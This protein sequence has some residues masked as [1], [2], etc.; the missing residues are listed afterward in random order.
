MRYVLVEVSR[1]EPFPGCGSTFYERARRENAS[2][3][4]FV[5]E[6]GVMFHMLQPGE[7]WEHVA[8]RFGYTASDA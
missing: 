3:A 7:T 8:R 2:I 4:R 1:S 6:R 5:M